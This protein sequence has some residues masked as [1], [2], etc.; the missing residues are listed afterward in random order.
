MAQRAFEHLSWLGN[1]FIATKWEV[2]PSGMQSHVV[3]SIVTDGSEAFLRRFGG[4]FCLPYS[5]MKME[6]VCS[7]ARVLTSTIYTMKYHT[8]T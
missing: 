7:L 3:W 8:K 1:D 2:L 6:A 5:A 4:T